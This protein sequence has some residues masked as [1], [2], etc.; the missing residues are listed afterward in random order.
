MPDGRWFDT[1]EITSRLSNEVYFAKVKDETKVL[2]DLEVLRHENSLKGMFV[3]KMLS[4]IEEKPE[5]A[6]ALSLALNIG[7]KA[8]CAEVSYN[9]D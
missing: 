9:E 2:H 6:D 8:F 1:A 4:L 5:E 7:L 3:S